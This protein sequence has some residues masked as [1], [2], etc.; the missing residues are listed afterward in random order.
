M[1]LNLV[2]SSYVG[3]ETTRSGFLRVP[4]RWDEILG[5]RTLTVQRSVVLLNDKDPDSPDKTL[6]VL[7][8]SALQLQLRGKIDEIVVCFRRPCQTTPLYQ[9]H[10]SQYQ[11]RTTSLPQAAQDVPPASHRGRHRLKP[12]LQH[13]HKHKHHA[14]ARGRRE[15]RTMTLHSALTGSSR[16]PQVN[17]PR[18]T[19]LCVSSFLPLSRTRSRHMVG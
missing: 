16:A 19:Y 3:Y 10:P 13:K 6:F 2:E 17:S 4:R 12:C 7:Q 5:I 18:W 11:C 15:S 9:E 1:M 8:A 14:R